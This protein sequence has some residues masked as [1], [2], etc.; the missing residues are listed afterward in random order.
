MS[1]CSCGCR[2]ILFLAFALVAA[3]TSSARVYSPRIVSGRVVDAYSAKTFANH[4]AWKNLAP[5]ERARAMFEYLTD[6]DT[7]LFPFGAGV[8]EGADKAHEFGLVRD[9]VK[10]INVYGYGN[11]E[12]I[13]PAMGGLW[14]QGG[15]GHARTID[16]PGWKH[17]ACEVLANDQWRY[18][19]LD[20]RGIF[21]SPDGTLRSLDD[22]RRDNAVW[23]RERSPRFFPMEDLP[24]LHKKFVQSNVGHRYSVAA[25]G[26]TMDFVLRRGEKF[27]RWWQP[28][29]GRWLVSPDDAKDEARRKLL[30]QEPRGPKPKH[31]ELTRHTYGNGQFV[32]EP[33]L[34]GNAS[35]F[36]DGVF[37]S[38]NVAVTDQC[39]TLMKPGD[40]WAV[41]EVRSPYVIVPLVGKLEDPKDDSQASIIEVDASEATMAWSP[42]FGDTWI[43][44]ESKQWPATVDLTAQVAGSY[45][46]LLKVALKGKPGTAVVRSLKMTTWVQLA[47]ATLPRLV[48]GENSFELKTGDHY[49]LAT[50]VLSIQPS[51]ADENAFLH[52]LLRPPK[53]Y[54]PASRT[55]RAKGSM[56][57][58]LPALPRTKIAWLSAGASFVMDVGSDA[59]M[60]GNS[61]AYAVNAPR[62][63]QPL[64][65]E[66]PDGAGGIHR[67]TTQV[68]GHYNVD[69]EIKLDQPASAVYVRYEGRPGL[70]TYRLFAHCIDDVPPPVSPMQVTHRW[71]EAGQPRESSKT[72]DAGG[73][74]YQIQ[75]G[76]SPVNESIEL[77]IPSVR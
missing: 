13:G 26:H 64:F 40:G 20:L 34:K 71:T 69:R 47:P 49:G 9:P 62:D 76:P 68:H 24:E 22:A 5:A 31:A 61:I 46:Y 15:C 77:A 18:L 51:S 2:S 36:E 28:Q 16:L 7:G 12:M 42:D 27:T 37:E 3:G 75:A 66:G 43:T 54:D 10:I 29:G 67:P 25:G 19:D 60:S 74:S 55:T 8:M 56:I 59:A 57:A 41:F 72:L 14:E 6:T 4:P 53:E 73:V 32:Y 48:E 11:A 63:F 33:N 17:A 45:G 50:R 52:Y 70:N 58:R 44:L 35:D 65:V 1:L 30:E 39:L 21:Q 38:H 23:E